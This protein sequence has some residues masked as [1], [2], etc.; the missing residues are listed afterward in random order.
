MG[1]LEENAESS[2]NSFGSSRPVFKGKDQ[3]VTTIIAA[4]K[5]Y[6]TIISLVFRGSKDNSLYFH[7]IGEIDYSEFENADH[8]IHKYMSHQRFD[9]ESR[10]DIFL[11]SDNIIMM[12]RDP[13][14]KMESYFESYFD[15]K[16]VI[17]DAIEPKLYRYRD[18]AVGILSTNLFLEEV[19]ELFSNHLSSNNDSSKKLLLMDSTLFMLDPKYFIKSVE[20]ETE[21]S[22][23]YKSKQILFRP[24]MLE[25]INDI[26]WHEEDRILNDPW[27]VNVLTKASLELPKRKTPFLKNFS[28]VVKGFIVDS[29]IPAYAYF[30][31]HPKVILPRDSNHLENLMNVKIGRSY[32]YKIHGFTLYAAASAMSNS[33][34]CSQD[35]QYKLSSL[36][37]KVRG[38]NKTNSAIFD[39]FDK[40]MELI[41]ETDYYYPDFGDKGNSAQISI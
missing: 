17:K 27:S 30:F 14:A 35:E 38:S 18:S 6:S 20:R 10:N 33:R 22:K 21:R 4:P 26:D 9:H 34:S 15:K 5:E 19:S 7:E 31:A 12:M 36:M 23:K 28:K 25:N 37:E 1:G 11:K 41:K 3:S 29:A 16:G 8:L 32:A 24:E 40:N 39:A 13:L 2:L